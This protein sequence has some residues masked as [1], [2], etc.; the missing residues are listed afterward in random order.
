MPIINV[1]AGQLVFGLRTVQ[2]TKGRELEDMAGQG[3]RHQSQ[4]SRLYGSGL[5]SS[6]GKLGKC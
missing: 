1:A 5:Y 2:E 6:W 3:T 4:G